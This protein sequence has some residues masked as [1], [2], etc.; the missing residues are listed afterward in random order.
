MLSTR[1]KAE[2]KSAIVYYFCF[3]KVRVTQVLKEKPPT[4]RIWIRGRKAVSVSMYVGS[5]LGLF[6]NDVIFFRWVGI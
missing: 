3:Y 2:T 5:H 1:K 4:F 6:T